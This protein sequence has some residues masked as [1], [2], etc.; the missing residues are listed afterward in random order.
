MSNVNDV[1]RTSAKQPKVKSIR[2]AQPW[3]RVR[4]LPSGLTR[5]RGKR[6]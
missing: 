4:K 2:G 5:S 3:A 1:N 6:R